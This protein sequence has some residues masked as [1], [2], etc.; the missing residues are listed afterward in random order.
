MTRYDPLHSCSEVEETIKV[1][2]NEWA[3]SSAEK[4][5]K[6]LNVMCK[7]SESGLLLSSGV[8]ADVSVV[9]S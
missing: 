1:W 9:A 7:C 8:P 3:Y 5:G 6:L 2:N 4:Y